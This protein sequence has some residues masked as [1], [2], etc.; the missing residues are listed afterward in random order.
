LKKNKKQE[1]TIWL[2]DLP[3]VCKNCFHWGVKDGN[4]FCFKKQ[5]K[6]RPNTDAK[7]CKYFLVWNNN[8]LK[9]FKKW[10]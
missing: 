2:K 6:K 5:D 4:T 10:K 7:Q 3:S 9:N 8:A 1:K